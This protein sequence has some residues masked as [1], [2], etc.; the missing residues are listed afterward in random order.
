MDVS[1][2]SVVTAAESSALAAPTDTAEIIIDLPP[3]SEV[4]VREV[5]DE[6]SFIE[7]PAD[8]RSQGWVR[9]SALTR[10]WPYSPA[11]IQ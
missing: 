1:R 3:G 11:L 7:V 10:L 2:R 6:W 4:L 5:R 9:T 8:E